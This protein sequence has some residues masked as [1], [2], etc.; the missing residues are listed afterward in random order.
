MRNDYSFGITPLRRL[1]GRWEV[2]I[3]KHRL[4]NH[5]GFPKGHPNPGETAKNCAIRELL[6]ETGLSITRMLSNTPFWESYQFFVQGEKIVK[7]VAYF[8]A[9]VT[10]TL[11]LQEVEIA[12]A[13]WVLLEEAASYLTFPQSK[14]MSLDLLQLTESI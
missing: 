10:G 1:E 9:E 4:G 8:P 12:A 11:V 7:T 13:K 14:Q 3:V 6:E 2:L 5:Y